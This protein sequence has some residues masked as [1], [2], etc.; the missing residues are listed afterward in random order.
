MGLGA[1][2]GCPPVTQAI[3]GL[4][5]DL[6]PSAYTISDWAFF[7]STGM[8]YKKRPFIRGRNE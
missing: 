3:L 2:P 6:L 5:V 1:G 7:G 4:F 8:V